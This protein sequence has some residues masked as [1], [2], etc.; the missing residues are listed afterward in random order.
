[1]K[2][3]LAL[4]LLAAVT[5]AAPVTPDDVTAAPLDVDEIVPEAPEDHLVEDTPDG[6]PE[7][8]CSGV[9]PNHVLTP[10]LR[11]VVQRVSN[12]TV[13]NYNAVFGADNGGLH[14]RC[15]AVYETTED[16]HVWRAYDSNNPY[17]RLGKWWTAKPIEGKVRT[18]RKSYE[19]CPKY[20]P[21]DKMVSCHLPKGA[22][23]VIGE[24]ESAKCSQY[25]TYP[26]SEE[27]Q[28]YL[29]KQTVQTVHSCSDFD[30]Y[31]NWQPRPPPN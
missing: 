15:A 8:D 24:G 6:N 9:D 4:A 30:G 14:A 29:P 27:L 5:H 10:V 28:V 19:I 1:M 25:L 3:F 26:R 21:I 12:E 2:I 23:V 22:H 18:Y 11:K 31:F 20:S 13:A 7:A 17:S 16:L